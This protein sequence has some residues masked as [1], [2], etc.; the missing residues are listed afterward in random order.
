MPDF[1]SK[2]KH[3]SHELGPVGRKPG[4]YRGKTAQPVGSNA[5]SEFEQGSMLKK[6]REAQEPDPRMGKTIIGVIVVAAILYSVFY[7]G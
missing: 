7:S 1:G 6:M 3:P 2:P 4:G 5:G